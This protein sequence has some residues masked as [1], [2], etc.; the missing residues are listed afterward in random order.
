MYSEAGGGG[1]RQCVDLFGK[2]FIN[3]QL[4][5]CGERAGVWLLQARVL[6]AL[7]LSGGPARKLRRCAQSQQ[8]MFSA[9]T[10]AKLIILPWSGVFSLISRNKMGSWRTVRNKDVAL[11]V[12]GVYMTIK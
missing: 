11:Y 4:R 9:A 2:S 12:E 3:K 10:V 5:A 6:P 8:E 1:F 7:H